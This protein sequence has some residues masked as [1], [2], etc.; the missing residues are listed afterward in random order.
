MARTT[1]THRDLSC[2]PSLSLTR[3]RFLGHVGGVTAAA[4]AAAAV[5]LP[6]LTPLAAK[7]AEA[8]EGNPT[9]DA[10]RAGAAYQI[11]HKAA[12]DEK[13]MPMPDHPVNGDEEAYTN[14]I[15]SYSKGLPHNALGEVDPTAYS[16]LIGAVSGGSSSGFESIPLGGV[17]RLSNPQAALAFDLEGADSHHLG[18]TPPPAFSSAEEAGEMTELYWQALTRD[19]PFLEYENDP[20]TNAAAADLSRLSDFRGPKADHRVTTGT[21]F[22]GDT[23]GDLTGPYLSQFLWKNVPYGATPIVQR[24]RTTVPNLDYMTSYSDWLVIQNGAAAGANQFDPTPRYIRNARDLT[25]FVHQDFSYQSFLNACLILFGMHAAFDQANPYNN[26]RTQTGFST[27]GSPHVLDL[28]AK[29]TNCG[30]KA[31]WYQKWSVHRRLRPEEFGGAVHNRQTNAAD[32]SVHNDLLNSQALDAVFSRTG[33]Y[34]LPQAYPEGCPTHPSYPAGHAVVAGACATALKA[35]FDESFVIPDPVEAGTD[36]LSLQPYMGGEL[37][38]GGELNKLAANI[39]IGR[40]AAGV[41]W[42]SDGIE[43][44]RLGE[45]VAISILRDVRGCFSENFDGFSLTKFDGTEIR[46]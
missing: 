16:A 21:L 39:A 9:K 22:R 40:N 5:G 38:V 28:V 36:G 11:R 29:V 24:I 41:H 10:Q 15:G 1:R 3:R 45:A 44:L 6:T 25:S 31:A 30:L 42:R 32:Y 46:V 17:V 43:G 23:A 4:A 13:N 19:V 35:F 27:F 37:T 20:L 8:A 26:S 7:T 18:L 34:L 2:Q 33:S 14:F 12:L